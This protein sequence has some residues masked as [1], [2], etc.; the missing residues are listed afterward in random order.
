MNVLRALRYSAFLL[1]GIVAATAQEPAVDDATPASRDVIDVRP[2]NPDSSSVL[3]LRTGTIVATNGVQ[4]IFQDATLAAQYIRLDQELGEAL[5]E[6][7]VSLQRAG[8][9]WTGTWV[10]M[11]RWIES[12]TSW[13]Q[14]IARCCSRQVRL[15]AWNVSLWYRSCRLCSV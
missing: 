10:P 13:L 14:A 3:D 15:L 5:A 8:T 2:L 4:V 9:T 11:L 6:G 12:A 1:V 7:K